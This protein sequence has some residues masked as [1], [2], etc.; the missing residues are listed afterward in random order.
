MIPWKSRTTLRLIP[1]K[2]H[3]K[4][5]EKPSVEIPA[6]QLLRNFVHLLSYLIEV[7][8]VSYLRSGHYWRNV[9]VVSEEKRVCC[10]VLLVSLIPNV[11][12]ASQSRCMGAVYVGKR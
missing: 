7:R 4:V 3:V 12:P 8:M 5:T 1:V 6:I 2:S 9:S 10:P 11:F